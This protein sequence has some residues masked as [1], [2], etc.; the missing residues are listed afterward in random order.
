MVFAL[1]L[2]L[3]S[4]TLLHAHEMDHMSKIIALFLQKW[5]EVSSRRRSG[6]PCCELCQYQYL[7]HKKF[8][9]R[10]KEA[11]CIVRLYITF[12]CHFRF[13]IGDSPSVPYVTSF[14][15]FSSLSMCAS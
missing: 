3:A 11:L 7:R 6:P 2:W 1:W 8:V 12:L 4:R 14:C 15:T 9:V 13:L 10:K 5:L